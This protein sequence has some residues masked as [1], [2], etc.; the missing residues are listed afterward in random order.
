LLLVDDSLSMRRHTD[1]A[2]LLQARFQRNWIALQPCLLSDLSP[3]STVAAART[4]RHQ[5]EGGDPPR[6]RLFVVSQRLS[7]RRCWCPRSLRLRPVRQLR[8]LTETK[9]TRMRRRHNSQCPSVTTTLVLG[10]PLGL[11]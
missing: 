9:S 5:G 11:M 10:V 8:N 3:T 7:S 1:R 6:A 2:E 4:F